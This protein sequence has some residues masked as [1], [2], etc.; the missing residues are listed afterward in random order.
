MSTSKDGLK[1]E[2]FTGEEKYLNEKRSW[3][4]DSIKRE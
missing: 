1:I 2:S 3:G 4:K